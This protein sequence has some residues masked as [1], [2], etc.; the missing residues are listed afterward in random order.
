LV[1]AVEVDGGDR[2]YPEARL[3]SKDE[4]TS[5]CKRLRARD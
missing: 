2:A 5:D 3:G 1:L 4:A